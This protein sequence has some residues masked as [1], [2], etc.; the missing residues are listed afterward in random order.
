MLTDARRGSVHANPRQRRGAGRVRKTRFFTITLRPRVLYGGGGEDQLD[1]VPND[2]PLLWLLVS[3]STVHSSM[4]PNCPNSVLTSFSEHFLDSMPTNNFLS[5]TKRKFKKINQSINQPSS[6]VSLSILR[7]G[8]AP[9]ALEG[10]RDPP[11]WAGG[12]RARQP[13]RRGR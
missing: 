9:G 12:G 6:Q 11:S 5:E 1:N 4:V 2:V 13:G 3:L 7:D 10:R 8:N